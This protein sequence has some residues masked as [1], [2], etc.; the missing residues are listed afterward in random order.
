[1]QSR[2]PKILLL[3]DD[4]H[5]NTGISTMS[6]EIILGTLKDFD[7]VQLAAIENHPKHGSV[8]DFSEWAR[9]TSGVTD[10][11]LMKYNWSGYGDKNALFDIINR[12]SPDV[13]LHF[14]DPRYWK[15]LYDIEREVRQIVPIAYYTIWDSLPVPKWNEPFYA[16][17]DLL[18]CISKQTYYIV[19]KVLAD[20]GYQD[21]QI[22]YVPHGINQN[23]FFPISETDECYPEFVSFRN[24]VL[25]KDNLDK[26]VFFFNSRNMT[27]K[28]PSDLI[29]AY[30]TFVDHL[31]DDK[32][33]STML[34]LHTEHV[35]PHGTNLL[36]VI[37]DLASGYNIR[38]T[39]RVDMSQQAM[40]YLYNMVDV[41]CQVSS[42]EGFGLSIAESITAGTPVLVNMTGGLID[43]TLP[44]WKDIGKYLTHLDFNDDYYNHNIG[45]TFPRTDL[46]GWMPWAEVV[47]PRVRTLQGSPATPYIFDDVA[48]YQDIAFAMREWFN[49]DKEYRKH[50]GKLGREKFALPEVGFSSV[51]MCNRI[52]KDINTLIANWKPVAP[53]KI[54]K[55]V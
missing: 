27:R 18:M 32:K 3:S 26:F 7:W 45:S 10:S 33:D 40:N 8:E 5:T 25:G 50:V 15:W 53:V 11:Y 24:E 31:P 28:H 43:Q 4:I 21:W 12:E 23:T 19:N 47:F 30:K 22:T 39:N 29:L 16:S 35:S 14:T 55:V 48:H 44:L 2:K 42:N 54:V 17:C 13:I 38:F 20:R 41:T 46:V 52:V 36:S 34:L 51:E 37:D 9:N 6:R 49:T 1:M